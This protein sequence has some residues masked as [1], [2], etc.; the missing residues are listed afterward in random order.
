[1]CLRFGWEWHESLVVSQY[2]GEFSGFLESLRCVRA[3][4][5]L[6]N[7]FV[8]TDEGAGRFNRIATAVGTTA[9]GRARCVHWNENASYNKQ[10]CA[11]RFIASFSCCSLNRHAHLHCAVYAW[12]MC[13]SNH[14]RSV[15][16]WSFFHNDTFVLCV[17]T[18][19][20]RH[21][22]HLWQ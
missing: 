11:T 20:I 9:C 10:K 1:M 3:R 5:C 14:G 2:C 15:L 16:L 6:D 17:V 19:E 22:M 4:L 13:F 18:L 21:G 7:V 8:T 12:S